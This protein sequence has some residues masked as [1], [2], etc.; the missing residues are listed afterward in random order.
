MTTLY[1]KAT[2]RRVGFTTGRE[3]LAA[4]ISSEKINNKYISCNFDVIISDSKSEQEFGILT[5]SGDELSKLLESVES[6]FS[7][8]RLSIIEFIGGIRIY[9]DSLTFLTEVKPS[10]PEFIGKYNL[11]LPENITELDCVKE[12]KT[13]LFKEISKKLFYD[14]NDSI[15]DLAKCVMAFVL[16]QPELTSSEKAKFDSLVLR[17]KNIYTKSIALSGLEDMIEQLENNLTG[18]YTAKNQLMQTSSIEDAIRIE[19]NG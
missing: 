7:I 5:G 9:F 18:Y 16:Y 10:F 17:A 3:P 19:Y 15:A 14:D 11:Q 6:V 1:I 2:P 8:K 13:N 4:Y 12:Y